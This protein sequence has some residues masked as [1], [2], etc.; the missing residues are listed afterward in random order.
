MNEKLELLKQAYEKALSK[1]AGF[2]KTIELDIY[3]HY[4]DEYPDDVEGLYW[5]LIE[6]FQE[7]NSVHLTKIFEDAKSKV[8]FDLA[9]ALDDYLYAIK[10]DLL[11]A[12]TGTKVSLDSVIEAA[13]VRFNIGG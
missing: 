9:F 13:K 2:R 5:R 8:M 7:E 10:M 4:G 6:N 1:L 11:E 3:N 12:D